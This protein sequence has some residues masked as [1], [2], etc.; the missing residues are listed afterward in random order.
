M[1]PTNSPSK[2]NRLG[3]KGGLGG[4]PLWE[5]SKKSIG[6]VLDAVGGRIPVIGVG[7]VKLPKAQIIWIWGVEH[8]RYTRK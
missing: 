8:C 5:I 2:I 7:G 1:Q 4:D 6:F 3:E